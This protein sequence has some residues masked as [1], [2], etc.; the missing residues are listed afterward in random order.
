MEPSLRG[1]DRVISL[2]YGFWNETFGTAA[3]YVYAINGYPQPQAGLLGTVMAGT[4]GSAMAFLMGQNIRPFRSERL[5]FDPIVSVGYFSDVDVYVD[6]NPGFPNHRAGS[7]E[8]GPRTTSLRAAAGTRPTACASSICCPSAAG[9]T[10][11][12]LR[13]S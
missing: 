11:C 1:Q 13:T 6:G 4:T 5:F 12:C 2:P 7:N 3:A 8:F 9:A 10:R